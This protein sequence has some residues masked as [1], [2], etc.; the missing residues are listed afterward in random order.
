MYKN[1]TKALAFTGRVYNLNLFSPLQLLVP[2]LIVDGSSRYLSEDLF[3]Y[4]GH[5]GEAV[6]FVTSDEL[7]SAEG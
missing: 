4:P 3:V 1:Y 7:V 6:Y 5:T 2:C